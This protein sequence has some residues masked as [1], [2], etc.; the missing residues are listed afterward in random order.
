MRNRDET[1]RLIETAAQK[2]REFRHLLHQLETAL[3]QLNGGT[4]IEVSC[5]VNLEGAT[6]EELLKLQR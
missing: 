2:Q 1:Q 6:V 3:T 5:L 4:T